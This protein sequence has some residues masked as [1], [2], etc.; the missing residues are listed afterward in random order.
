MEATFS[1]ERSAL[2]IRP[3]RP[4]TL[5]MSSGA[6]CSWITNTPLS[7]TSVTRTNSGWVTRDRA[8][9]STKSRI[10]YS[11]ALARDLTCRRLGGLALHRQGSIFQNTHAG[12]QAMHAF[13]GLSAF[14]HPGEGLFLID[15]DFGRLAARAIVP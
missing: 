13:T 15:H 6:T 4:I 12:H 7:S 2:A 9:Y 11:P 10:G 5:P 8:T 3:C 14:G 1:N